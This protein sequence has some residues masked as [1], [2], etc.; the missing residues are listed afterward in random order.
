MLLLKKLVEQWGIYYVI[1]HL[2]KKKNWNIRYISF[3]VLWLLQELHSTNKLHFE[4]NW[5]KLTDHDG[6]SWNV[7]DNTHNGD[8]WLRF[9][10]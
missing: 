4:C 10:E 5:F 2:K 3:G 1:Y 7:V 9:T 6:G 8:T